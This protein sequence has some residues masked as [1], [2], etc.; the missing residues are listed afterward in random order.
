MIDKFE[1]SSLGIL[2]L[3]AEE[4]SSICTPVRRL[5]RRVF[6]PLGCVK[7]KVT[8]TILVWCEGSATR[9]QPFDR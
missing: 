2:E 9:T 7:D 4:N 1:G 8:S 6:P 3:I 5:G